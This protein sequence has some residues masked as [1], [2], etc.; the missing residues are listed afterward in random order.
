[1][2]EGRRPVQDMGLEGKVVMVTGAGSGI[3]RAAVAAFA[4]AGALV[5]AAGRRLEPL[6]TSLQLAGL[7][8]ENGLAISCDVTDESSVAHAVETTVSRFGRLDAAVNTAGSFGPTSPLAASRYEDAIE[9]VSV[10]LIGMWLC[11][12]HQAGAM[13]SAGGGSI[14]TTG[15]VASFL[16]HSGS[17]MYAASKHGVVGLTKSAA[18]QL[19]PQNIR[20]N[21]ICPGSTDTPML[22]EL[23]P[24][25]A[26][27]QARASR[28][29]LGRIGQPEEAAAAAVWLAS[30]WSSYVTGQAL[31]ID[32]GVTAGSPA[33]V[34]QPTN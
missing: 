17:P 19:A 6:D 5:V 25:A 10:N 21:A 4:A 22:R 29:P 20:V 24:D 30:P 28:A 8:T 27:L 16:G 26:Q 9:V 14:V 33:P 11:L 2:H 15:S 13:S 32:G 23:Y 18:L 3:G 1:M 7:T 34:R 31:A 12:K